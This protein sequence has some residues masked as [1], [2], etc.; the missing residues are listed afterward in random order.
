MKILNVSYTRKNL[1]TVM[2][3]VNKDRKPVIITSERG[4]P[5][6]M[7]SLEDYNELEALQ[8][9]SVSPPASETAFLLRSSANAK[10][11]KEAAGRAGLLKKKVVPEMT[12]IELA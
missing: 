1:A 11:L 4:K 8:A 5:V 10:R 2:Q 9:N 7:I 3:C 6:V 12:E